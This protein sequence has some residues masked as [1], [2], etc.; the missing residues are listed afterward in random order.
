MKKILSFC[1]L[2]IAAAKLFAQDPAPVLFPVVDSKVIY[3]KVVETPG[4][5]GGNL[6]VRAS[7]WLLDT[8][9]QYKPVVD[10]FDAGQLVYQVQTTVDMYTLDFKIQIDSKDNKYRYRI[11]DIKRTVT[12]KDESSLFSKYLVNVPAEKINSIVAGEEKGFSKG[13]RKEN[14]NS[15]ILIQARMNAYINSLQKALVI[16]KEEF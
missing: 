8:F 6:Y 10:D 14:Q 3:E 15:I 2:L 9:E 12:G 4:T 7:K 13:Q 11:F 5:T 1:L 16:K